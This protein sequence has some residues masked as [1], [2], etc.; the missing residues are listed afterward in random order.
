MVFADWTRTGSGVGELDGSVKHAGNSSYRAEPFPGLDPN[1]LT[2]DTFS[3]PQAQITLWTIKASSSSH[4][5]QVV[6]HTEYGSL[7]CLPDV[8]DTWQRWRLTFWYEAATNTKWGRIEKWINTAWV[9]QGADDTNFGAGSPSSGA[10]S[11]RISYG[12]Y[13][14]GATAFMWFDEVEVS[15]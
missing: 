6:N 2:H 1:V 11:L 10:L 3:E 9:Q 13:P 8:I 15:A 12:N 14:G 4:C 5:G 7:S